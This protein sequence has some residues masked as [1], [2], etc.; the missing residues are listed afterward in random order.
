MAK[1][2]YINPTD[3]AMPR[4]ERVAPVEKCEVILFP[5]VRYERWAEAPSQPKPTKKPRAKKRALEMAD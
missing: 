3:G 4:S 2:Y 5:G 1:V